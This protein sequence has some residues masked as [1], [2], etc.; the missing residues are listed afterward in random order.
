MIQMHHA[1]RALADADCADQHQQRA[2]T[3]TFQEYLN[4]HKKRLL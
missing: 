1:Y 2:K 3:K 4:K